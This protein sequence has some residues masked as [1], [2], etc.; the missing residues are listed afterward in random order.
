ML[1]CVLFLIVVV[2]L[3]KICSFG[4]KHAYWC[5]PRDKKA[6]KTTWLLGV[7]DARGYI[8]FFGEEFCYESSP[9]VT[10]GNAQQSLYLSDSSERFFG[11]IP[12]FN[13]LPML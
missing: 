5:P 10:Q 6:L 12:N 1:C 13:S 11:S 7:T 2:G 8:N 3:I 4:A 9:Y